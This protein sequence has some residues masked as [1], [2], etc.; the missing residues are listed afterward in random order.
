MG[1]LGRVSVRFFLFNYIWCGFRVELR[2]YDTIFIIVTV[3]SIEILYNMYHGNKSRVLGSQLK[4]GPI[5]NRLLRRNS[6]ILS[7]QSSALWIGQNN[8]R[9]F[10]NQVVELFSIT[11]IFHISVRAIMSTKNCWAKNL[12]EVLE[13]SV[14]LLTYAT[15]LIIQV[16]TIP[17]KGGFWKFFAVFLS[18]VT[19]ISKVWCKWTKIFF[20][21]SLF[22]LICVSFS[23]S[24]YLFFVREIED[25]PMFLDF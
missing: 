11:I 18:I 24:S 12:R 5:N 1:V 4:E 9:N 22:L 16:R 10:F 13:P 2:C 19:L 8:S 21:L 14:R 7:E 15:I 17:S 3:W 6:G 23:T 25:I 20:G